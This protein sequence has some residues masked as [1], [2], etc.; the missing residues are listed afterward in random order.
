MGSVVL[1]S[2]PRGAPKVKVE[3]K[4][5]EQEAWGRNEGEEATVQGWRLREGQQ[6]VKISRAQAGEPRP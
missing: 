2:R 5:I 3:Q 1:R 6:S 4:S